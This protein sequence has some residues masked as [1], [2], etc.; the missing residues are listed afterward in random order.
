MSDEIVDGYGDAEVA[1]ELCQRVEGRG[2]GLG[3]FCPHCH[4]YGAFDILRHT[5]DGI[6]R[7]WEDAP[8][9]TC[10]ACQAKFA[11]VVYGGLLP[12]EHAREERRESYQYPLNLQQ[13]A[14]CAVIVQTCSD[15][16]C[17][18]DGCQAKVRGD[19]TCLDTFIRG[20][21]NAAIIALAKRCGLYPK[22]TD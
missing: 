21:D 7:Q 12:N 9:V 14:H 16:H 15:C 20:V 2:G 3:L 8:I 11:V 10:D 19:Q 18:K 1:R 17:L 6:I 13:L 4:V 22:K 5:K